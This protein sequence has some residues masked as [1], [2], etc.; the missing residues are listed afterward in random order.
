MPPILNEPSGSEL[1]DPLRILPVAECEPRTS[2]NDL[3]HGLSVMQH[4]LAVLCSIQFYEFLV[5]FGTGWSGSPVPS[6]LIGRASSG[7]FG[8][9]GG[10]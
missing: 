3:A 2:D 1:R 4:V 5:I 9:N 7:A 6:L 10:F 8:G